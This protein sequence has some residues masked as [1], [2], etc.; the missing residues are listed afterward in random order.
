MKA[1]TLWTRNVKY[2]RDSDGTIWIIPRESGLNL[3]AGYVGTEQLYPRGHQ[4]W[5]NFRMY[6]YRYRIT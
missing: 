4:Y 2:Q 1:F 5:F 6:P 3:E